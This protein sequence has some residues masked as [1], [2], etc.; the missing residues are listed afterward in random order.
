MFIAEDVSTNTFISAATAPCA[1]AANLYVMTGKMV[2]GLPPPV[3]LII[4]NAFF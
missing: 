3:H 2:A 4:D 1:A